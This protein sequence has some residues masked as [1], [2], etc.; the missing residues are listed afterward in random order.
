MY[1]RSCNKNLVPKQLFV[2]AGVGKSSIINA[3][4]FNALADDG[5]A[6][7]C[8]GDDEDDA[9]DDD[10]AERRASHAD[11][12]TLGHTLDEGYREAGLQPM[13]AASGT[14]GDADGFQVRTSMSHAFMSWSRFDTTV[15]LMPTDNKRC[16]C[17]RMHSACLNT[18]PKLKPCTNLCQDNVCIAAQAVGTVS[19]KLRR[20]KH[21]TRSVRLLE[22][23]SGDGMLADTPGFNQPSLEGLS[24]EQLPDSFPEIRA[25][26]ETARC[27][28]LVMV[29]A[30]AI[31]RARVHTDDR[32]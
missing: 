2:S 1:T 24:L 12:S 27:V 22:T 29:C 10:V 15:R 7:S 32:V 21:T 5:E 3:L 16:L 20:G 9:V 4:R 18:C 23:R 19:A 25:R 28:L 6:P 17:L 26:L 8:S 30:G 11:A 31:L 14:I 13:R